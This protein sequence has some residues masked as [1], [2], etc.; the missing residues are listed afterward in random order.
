MELA[1]V[2]AEDTAALKVSWDTDSIL[3]EQLQLLQFLIVGFW[4][5][6]VILQD[7]LERKGGKKNKESD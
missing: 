4:V 7:K 3:S 5:L 1:Q 2:L 6:S